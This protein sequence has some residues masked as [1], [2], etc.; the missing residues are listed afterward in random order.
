MKTLK[1][2]LEDRIS[3]SKEEIEQNEKIIKLISI[4]PDLRIYSNRWNKEYFSS[5]LVNKIVTDVEFANACGCCADAPL[6][7]K[8]YVE[9]DGIKIY[10][11]PVEVYIGEGSYGGSGYVNIELWENRLDALNINKNVFE[12][13]EKYLEDNKFELY[14]DLED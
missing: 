1:E 2:K 10:A 13:V 12:K 5:K 3:K 7:A 6:Y 4:Y 11:E 8:F 14:E 9:I